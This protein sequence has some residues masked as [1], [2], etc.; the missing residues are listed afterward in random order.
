MYLIY[1][2]FQSIFIL[3]QSKV[4]LFK[5]NMWVEKIFIR[6]FFQYQH[7]QNF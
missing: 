3:I 4:L 5:S 1:L 2:L 6:S 7:I